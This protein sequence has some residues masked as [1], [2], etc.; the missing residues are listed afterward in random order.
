MPE[1][2]IGLAS[3]TQFS[4][5]TGAVTP[6]VAPIVPPPARPAPIVPPE[7]PRTSPIAVS[8][9]KSRGP[10]LLVGGGVVFLALMGIAAYFLLRTSTPSGTELPAAPVAIPI[11]N[12]E[13]LPPATSTEAAALSPEAVPPLSGGAARNAVDTDVDG[14]TDE[15]ER[16]Y[17]SDPLRPDSDGD[18]FLD[19]NE[20]FHLYSPTVPATSTLKDAYQATVYQDPQGLFSVLVPAS[21]TIQS[22]EAASNTVRFTAGNGEYVEVSS[23]V[24]GSALPALTNPFTTKQGY[25]A[26]RSDDRQVVSAIVGQSAVALRY[27]V[28]AYPEAHFRRTFEM[29]VNSL[30]ERD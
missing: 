18:G 21:W 26:L 2:F 11:E 4:A 5:G 8:G 15:E 24:A 17:G 16:L 3:K 30:H 14:L 9:A 25:A 28:G 10:I 23:G 29:M 6:P 7:Q 27:S 20:V 12:A 13:S 19:G 22:L 1:Q